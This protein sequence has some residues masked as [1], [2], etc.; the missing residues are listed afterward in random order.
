MLT[1]VELI[2]VEIL[3]RLIDGIMKIKIPKIPPWG[4]SKKKIYIKVPKWY[5]KYIF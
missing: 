4:A 5:P 3:Y 2:N 1:I